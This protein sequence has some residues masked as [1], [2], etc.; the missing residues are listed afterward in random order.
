MTRDHSGA[1]V[2]KPT[3][4]PNYKAF[5]VGQMQIGDKP[6]MLKWVIPHHQGKARF[7]SHTLNKVHLMID[8]KRVVGHRIIAASEQNWCSG[9]TF[10]KADP[11]EI[12]R[13]TFL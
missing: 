8:G 4:E 12:G 6:H 1:E 5:E 3:D 11:L 10:L 9:G 7:S 2:D 13:M